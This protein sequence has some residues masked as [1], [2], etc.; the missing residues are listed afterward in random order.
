MTISKQIQNYKINNISKNNFNNINIKINNQNININKNLININSIKNIT[1]NINLNNYINSSKNNF[2]SKKISANISNN[3]RANKSK[4]SHLNYSNYSGNISKDSTQNLNFNPKLLKIK[5]VKGRIRK[6]KLGKPYLEYMIELTYLSKKW[7]I[8]KRFSQFTN[9][10]KSLKKMEIQEGLAIPK[11][12]NIFSNIGTVFSGLSH[13]NKI[14][15]LEKFLKDIS[16]YDEINCTSL[17]R[18][19]FETENLFSE[20]RINRNSS[21][22][23]L[24]NN[25]NNNYL[26]SKKLSDTSCLSHQNNQTNSSSFS[27][28]IENKLERMVQEIV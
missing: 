14:L 1:N 10:Y 2:A 19:F 28:N 26:Y 8:N 4:I 22:I 5:I 15:N 7:T 23:H 17:Y 11:S 24:S 18:N 6:D 12:A 21:N 27:N 13:E 3:S 25:I 20:L 9:L 16:Q